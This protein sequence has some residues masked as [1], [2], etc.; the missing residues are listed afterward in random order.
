[1]I[2]TAFDFREDTPVGLDP[3]Q[4]SPTLRRYHSALWS[5]PLPSGEAFEL[6][7]DVPGSYLH[8]RSALGV[9]SLASDSMVPTY[10]RW[11]ATSHVIAQIPADEQESF[12]GLA[13]TIGG[14]I[15]YP[16]N[17]V[18]GKLT[19][20]GA[21]GF[22]RSVADR[23]D[24]T[25]ECIRRHYGGGTSPL[26][27][28]LERYAGFFALFGSFE[29]Y[30]D[31]FLLQ[32]LVGGGGSTVRFLLPFDDFTVVGAVPT[33]LDAYVRYRARTVDF[34]QARNRRIARLAVD[35]S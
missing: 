3:D 7:T 33:T 28:T 24:L 22:T 13:Y 8:H 1:M 34:L 32:D 16:A 17:K 15:V 29:G 6:R 9:F 25:L 20:N 35:P 12:L 14:M 31:F 18:D 30:V 26:S 2:N 23:I 10:S 21:R 19:I 5:R 27:A 4:H 11:A